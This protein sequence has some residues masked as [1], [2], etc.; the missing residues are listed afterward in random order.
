MNRPSPSIKVY[1]GLLML[2]VVLRVA[3]YFMPV[4]F[5][6]ADQ[7]RMVSWPSILAI[8]ALGLIGVILA[9]MAGFPGMWD[10]EIQN[11]G[12]L[13]IPVLIGLSFGLLSVVLDLVQ[14]LGGEIQIEFPASLVVYPMGGIL[15][16]IIFRLLLTTLLV[17]LISTVILRGR[18]QQGIFWMV[19]VFV[20]LLY[21][22]LQIS[23]YSMITEEVT[24]LVGIHFLV[25]IGPYFVVAAYLYRRYGFFSAVAMRLADYLV[26]HIIWGL[27]TQG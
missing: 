14:P 8:W 25:L 1:L 24:L 10:K 4:E 21:A 26:W 3:L 13:F 27:L 20:G 12:R 17:W 16:E 2:L 11:R 7:E 5:V 9:P 23:A 22:F 6:L 15:E 19:A 18:W